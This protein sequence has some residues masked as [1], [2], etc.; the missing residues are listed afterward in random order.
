MNLLKH[1]KDVKH[2]EKDVKHFIMLITEKNYQRL[3]KIDN[4]DFE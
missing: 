3:Y 1:E 2:F 4:E